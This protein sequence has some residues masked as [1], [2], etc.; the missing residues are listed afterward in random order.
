VQR[1]E[2]TEQKSAPKK[3]DEPKDV[4]EIDSVAT[5]KTNDT[6]LDGGKKTTLEEIDW[7]SR[8]NQVP[9]EEALDAIP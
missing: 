5:N 7:Q 2:S 6:N 9:D 4:E 3:I 1:K 8:T